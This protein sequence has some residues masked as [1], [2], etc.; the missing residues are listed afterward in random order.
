MKKLKEKFDIWSL[1]Y[2]REIVRFIM[3]LVILLSIF[4]LMTGCA[5]PSIEATG[6]VRV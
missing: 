3:G 6:G 5:M 2:R 1:Y 4:M